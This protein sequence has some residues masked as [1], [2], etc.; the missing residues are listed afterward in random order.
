MKVATGGIEGEDNTKAILDRFQKA[1]GLKASYAPY[2]AG[3]A[4]VKLYSAEIADES[5]AKSL[6]VQFE[7]ETALKGTIETVKKQQPK[8]KIAT[9]SIQGETNAKNLLKQ[10]EKELKV[11]GA[12]E[13]AGQP[14]QLYNVKS[15][16]FNDEKSAKNAAGQIKKKTGLA[17]STEKVK[18]TRFWI[19]SMKSVDS[20]NLKKI[21]A[22]FKENVALYSLQRRGKSRH[23][24]ESFPSR[25]QIKRKQTMASGFLKTKIFRLLRKAPAARP[26]AASGLRL[27]KPPF[28][29]ESIKGLNSL[30]KTVRR[31]RP[32]QQEKSVQPLSADNGIRIRTEQSDAGAQ[33]L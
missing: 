32:D 30:R 19:V 9:S 7:K 5:K 15:G 26:S 6:L 3:Q 31:E 4:I 25:F 23:L 27:L 20:Q 11:K 10:F 28:K 24:S 8:Y 16:Y 1:T 14:A 22:F 18:G 21:D 33:F 13:A 29:R 2:G 17:S 12:Y